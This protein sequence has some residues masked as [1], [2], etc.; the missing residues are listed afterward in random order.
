MFQAA[1]VIEKQTARRFVKEEI[2]VW[3]QAFNGLFISIVFE[4]DRE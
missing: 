4:S 1:K 3:H 2:H